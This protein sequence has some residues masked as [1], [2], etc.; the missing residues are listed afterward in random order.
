M[1][2]AASRLVKA[3]PA[4][5]QPGYVGRIPVRNLWLLMLYASDLFRMMGTDRIQLEQIPDRLPDIVAEILAHAVDKRLRRNL[6]LGYQPRRAELDRVRGRIDLLATESRQ[7]LRRGKVACRFEELTI[8]TNRNR[9]VRG[10]LDSITPLVKDRD[11]AHR[12]RKLARDLRSLGVTGIVPTREQMSADRFGRHDTNDQFMVAAAKLAFDLKLPT[13]DAGDRA[14]TMPDRDEQWVRKLF[15]RAVYGFYSVTL[16]PK[17]WRVSGGTVLKWQIEAQTPRIENIL[18]TMKTDIVLE[19]PASARKIVIDTKFNKLLIKGQY[20]EESL[21]SSYIFQIYA[22][23]RSQV[24]GGT[25][26]GITDGLLLHPS[27]G[28]HI[29]EAV[30][31]QGHLIRFATVD[32]TAGAQ[33][34]RTDLLRV[35]QEMPASLVTIS[36]S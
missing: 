4:N 26:K 29:D 25:V 35:A 1:Q 20:R 17:Q 18:P 7:L 10:A 19:Q 12:C 11:V 15:E 8:D 21:R 34:I 6:S 3:P 13:E 27:V 28:E 9:Y 36:T 32:L 31:I 5:T 14:L 30:R 24:D 16:P 33:D 2:E 23:L 22:Y